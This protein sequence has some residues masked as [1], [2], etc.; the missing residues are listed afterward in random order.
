MTEVN[1]ALIGYAFMGRAHSNAWRQVGRFFQPKVTPRMKVICGRNRGAVRKASRTLGWEEWATDW[2]EVVARDDID[3]VSLCSP[4]FLRADEIIRCCEAG[5]HIF[6]EKPIIHTLEELENADMLLHVIDI[7]H[8]Q[9][10]AQIKSVERILEEL[11]LAQIPTL[12]VLNK[13]PT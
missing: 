11:D 2:R 6:A 8:P 10:Q 7:S 4:N 1:V 13:Q 12:R 5:K 3:I 9:Y